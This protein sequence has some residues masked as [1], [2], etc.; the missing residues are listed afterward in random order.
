VGEGR[1]AVRGQ[2]ARAKPSAKPNNKPMTTYEAAERLGLSPNDEGG[3]IT[4]RVNVSDVHAS[5]QVKCTLFSIPRLNS[6][7]G[8]S[9]T[10]SNL[11]PVKVAGESI[12]FSKPVASAPNNYISYLCSIPPRDRLNGVSQITSYEVDE[13]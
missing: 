13:L 9:S 2:R 10:G 12:L 7:G 3:S 11:I 8:A 5:Q 4:G 6:S 1:G